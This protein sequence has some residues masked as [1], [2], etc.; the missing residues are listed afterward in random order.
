M[1]TQKSDKWRSATVKRDAGNLSHWKKDNIHKASDYIMSGKIDRNTPEFVD[2]IFAAMSAAFEWMPEQLADA[3]AL[4]RTSVEHHGKLMFPPILVVGF[5]ASELALLLTTLLAQDDAMLLRSDE[6]TF[7]ADLESEIAKRPGVQTIALVI[8]PTVAATRILRAVLDQR[9]V[10]HFNAPLFTS[11]VDASNVSWIMSCE[12]GT[13]HLP[14]AFINSVVRIDLPAMTDD[15]LVRFL[16]DVAVERR[17][18]EV[19]RDAQNYADLLVRFTST[20]HPGDLANLMRSY[21]DEGM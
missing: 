19:A 3:H 16:V 1:A 9:G 21:I 15:D 2:Q 11:P 17:G 5:H 12:R 7:A 20:R 6:E 4:I 8:D 18:P 14:S 10:R 13:D